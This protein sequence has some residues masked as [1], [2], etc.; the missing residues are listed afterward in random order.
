M[1]ENRTSGSV[2]G[3]LGNRRSYRERPRTICHEHHI[4]K[5]GNMKAQVSK[6]ILLT[7]AGFTKNFG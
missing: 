6:T 7:G 2:R 1:R 4:N 5:S 3:A